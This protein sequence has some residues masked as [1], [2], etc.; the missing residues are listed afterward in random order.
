VVALC[1]TD[2]NIAEI[3]YPIPGNDASR[4]SI[5]FFLKKMAEAFEA[6]KKEVVK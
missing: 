4:A 6:G 1:G 2:N 3:D 5:E